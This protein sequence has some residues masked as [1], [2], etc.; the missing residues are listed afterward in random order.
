MDSLAHINSAYRLLALCARA[1]ATDSLYE[2]ISAQAKNFTAWN[3]LP[4]QA[5]LHG[6]APLLWHHLKHSGAS[7]PKQTEQTLKGL[8]LR[9][10][11]LNQSH[12]QT[13][14]EVNRLLQTSGIQIAV[15]KGL[16]LAYQYYSDPALRPTSDLDLL[17]RREDVPPAVQALARAGF[18]VDPPPAGRI[19]KEVKADSPPRNGI[20][21]RIEIHHYDPQGRSPVDNLPDDEFKGFD[22]PFEQIN[23]EGKAV[24]APNPSA[25]LDYLIRHLRRHLFPA[26]P[27]KPLQLKWVADIISL[28]EHHAPSINWR[29]EALQNRLEVL[30]SMTIIPKDVPV[31]KITPPAGVN[32]YPN[33][34]PQRCFSE[35][36]EA[37]A[38][39]FARR[40]FSSPS[41]WWLRLYYGLGEHQLWR[42]RL[43]YR[44]QILKMIL[45]AMRRRN[46]AIAK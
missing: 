36:K 38:W 41:D 43:A 4:A 1:R 20:S 19:P 7:I 21:T 2:E 11:T 35:W 6:M 17:L 22:A 30:Y 23:I 44:L 37:G 46:A 8:Y 3:S 24:F 14:I 5:E 9:H 15:L 42:G 40:T 25:M 13:L 39:Q 27:R 16:A 34:W 10:R 32:E 45:W 26:T 28:V 33:G 12:A 31:K 29:D 18:R